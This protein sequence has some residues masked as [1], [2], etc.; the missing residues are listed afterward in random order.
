MIPLV[1]VTAHNL[2]TLAIADL[3]ND[4]S[5]AGIETLFPGSAGFEVL[6]GLT[7]ADSHS[8]HLSVRISNLQK[9]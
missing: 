5:G 2:A 9:K 1:F 8:P 3:A 6:L 4:F 7:T